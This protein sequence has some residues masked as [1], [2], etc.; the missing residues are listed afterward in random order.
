MRSAEEAVVVSGE[1]PAAPIPTIDPESF[2]DFDGF[3]ETTLSLITDPERNAAMRTTGRRCRH[4]GELSGE[5]PEPEGSLRHQL[6]AAVADPRFCKASSAL[7]GVPWSAPAKD[8]MDTS[9]GWPCGCPVRLR[10]S[11]PSS[12]GS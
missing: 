11:P 3:R 5:P 8:T 1:D 2:E 4:G 9:H 7:L 6:R 10:R 12:T